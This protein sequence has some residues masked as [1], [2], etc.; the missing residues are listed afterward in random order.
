[1]QFITLKK[2][3]ALATLVAAHS[4]NAAPFIGTGYLNISPTGISAFDVTPA[5]LDTVDL[6]GV[7]DNNASYDGWGPIN[8]NF[9]SSTSIGGHIATVTSDNSFLRVEQVKLQK[10]KIVQHNTL[11]MQDF[12]FDFG[13]STLS[14]KIIGTNLLTNVVTDYGLSPLFTSALGVNGV[15]GDG[16]FNTLGTFTLH[17]ATADKFLSI[18]QVTHPGISDMYRQSDWGSF[19]GVISSVPEPAVY[20]SALVGLLVVGAARTARSPTSRA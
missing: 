5:W 3:L 9:T 12:V 19:S 7:V 16:S 17:T 10:G 18:L 11:L 20:L 13:T 14:A 8:L 15:N 6:P 2:T 1:M 4:S